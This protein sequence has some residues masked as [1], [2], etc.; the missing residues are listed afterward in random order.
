M[1]QLEALARAHAQRLRH[2]T[3]AYRCGPK[4]RP[5]CLDSS[6]D[7]AEQMSFTFAYNVISR[8]RISETEDWHS[9]RVNWL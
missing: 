3:T 8:M 7:R 2:P 9:I 6:H 1:R 4:R 5:D